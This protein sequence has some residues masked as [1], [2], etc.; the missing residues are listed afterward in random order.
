MK[1]T[2][3][4]TLTLVSVEGSHFNRTESSTKQC[5]VIHSE[6]IAQFNLSQSCPSVCKFV[7]MAI[8]IIIIIIIITLF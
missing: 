7:T 2:K 6:K 1:G 4:V 8:I 3:T 5:G